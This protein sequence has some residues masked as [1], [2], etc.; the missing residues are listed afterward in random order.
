MHIG[1]LILIN[2]GFGLSDLVYLLIFFCILLLL[3][4]MPVSAASNYGSEMFANVPRHNWV[5]PPKGFIITCA[6]S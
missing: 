4:Q 6:N 1:P 3:N 5:K 2:C